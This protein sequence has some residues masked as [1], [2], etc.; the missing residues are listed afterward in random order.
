MK[1]NEINV[2][3]NA[4]KSVSLQFIFEI[5]LDK[6]SKFLNVTYRASYEL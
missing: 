5:F 4:Q 3:S 1:A 6:G 2:V